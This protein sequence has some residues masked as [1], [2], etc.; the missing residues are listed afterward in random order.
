MSEKKKETPREE[1][2]RI[3]SEIKKG[4]YKSIFERGFSGDAEILSINPENR[5]DYYDTTL[6]P[7][8]EACEQ[9]IIESFFISDEYKAIEKLAYKMA[10][11]NCDDKRIRNF[12]FYFITDITDDIS[13][14]FKEYI[15]GKRESEDQKDI[16]LVRAIRILDRQ[17]NLFVDISGAMDS[18]QIILSGLG[19]ASSFAERIFKEFTMK[20]N[21]LKNTKPGI[22]IDPDK[23]A[24]SLRLTLLSQSTFFASFLLND[25]VESLNI[26]SGIGNDSPL[27]INQIIGHMVE[28]M[29]GDIE[30]GKP[31]KI[32]D[33]TMTK[34]MELLRKSKNAIK[35][36][37][38][39]SASED[40]SIEICME[41]FANLYLLNAGIISPT[42]L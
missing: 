38:L 40:R 4:T 41:T 16:A 31:L 25:H 37:S 28:Q 21:R 15:Q 2:K 20:R 30:N 17:M 6:Y 39:T 32:K 42:N 23:L 22:V 33:E 1:F 26:L 3:I 5:R 10:H 11:E 29:D 9:I 12:D 7:E 24:R 35:C 8:R 14:Y 34:L 36:P 27:R 13:Q 18:E 19:T